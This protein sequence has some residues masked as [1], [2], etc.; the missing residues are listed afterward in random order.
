MNITFRLDFHIQVQFHNFIP[1]NTSMCGRYTLAGKPVDLEKNFRAQLQGEGRLPSFNIA[2]SHS[3]PVILQGSP[4]IIRMESW[5]LVPFW[6]KVGEVPRKLINTRTDTLLTKPSFK[7]YINRKRC[8]VPATGFYEWKA[9]PTGKQPYYIHLKEREIFS[10]AG[11]WEVYA[12]PDG[13]VIYTF[14]II[15]TEANSLMSD[16]HQRMPVILPKE[17]E[18]LWLEDTNIKRLST[19]LVPYA[20]EKMEVYP[21]SQRVNSPAANSSELIQ[22]I[23]TNTLF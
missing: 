21:V 18:E 2:P 20:S 16:L 5:G 9:S 23:E 14:S 11:I 17:A 19:L 3:A 15:T 4:D 1:N 6:T 10:F 7:S 22:R 8:L 12:N 13:E